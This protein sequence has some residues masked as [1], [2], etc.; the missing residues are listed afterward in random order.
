MTSAT[1][2]R[3]IKASPLHIRHSIKHNQKITS[4]NFSHNYHHVFVQGYQNGIV[5][6][7]LQKHSKREEP[8]LHPDYKLFQQN[9]T[10][11]QSLGI[12]AILE[13]KDSYSNTFIS[14]S[15]SQ[16]NYTWR[17]FLYIVEGINN[18]PTYRKILQKN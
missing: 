14:H 6:V 7:W 2:P 15:T 4:T 11:M 3:P 10:L 17:Q 16:T 5:L 8:Y 18:I 9:P 13:C 12:C 1:T